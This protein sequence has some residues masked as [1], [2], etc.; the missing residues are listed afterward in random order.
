MPLNAG[1]GNGGILDRERIVEVITRFSRIERE[2]SHEISQKLGLSE[3]Q[4]SHLHYLKMI[5]GTADMT[6]GQLARQLNVTR[7]SVTGIV[8]KL[9]E[10]G[11]AEKSRCSRDRRV[12][13]I[14]LTEKGRH[15]TRLESLVRQ[16]IVDIIMNGLTEQE[17]HTFIRLMKKL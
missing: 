10:L 9:I 17:I 3:L 15:I 7:P 16:R 5:D 11:V 13:H 14:R 12:F 4:T 6:C 2:C 1:P 8:N